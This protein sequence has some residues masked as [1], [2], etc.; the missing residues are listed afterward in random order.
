MVAST[1]NK[2]WQ[3]EKGPK[4]SPEWSPALPRLALLAPEAVGS[5]GDG[6]LPWAIYGLSDMCLLLA[7][8]K[9][10]VGPMCTSLECQPRDLLQLLACR[11]LCQPGPAQQ[12]SWVEAFGPAGQV[13]FGIPHSKDALAPGWL[14]PSGKNS[15]TLPLYC[16]CFVTRSGARCI[17]GHL[18]TLGMKP[19][20]CE[21]MELH[22]HICVP[23]PVLTSML[24][25]GV[26]ICWDFSKSGPCYFLTVRPWD[27]PVPLSYRNLKSYCKY[28]WDHVY[29]C[30]L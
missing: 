29:G 6:D 10:P 26:E 4:Q 24:Q 18:R 11:L 3:R 5:S 27:L 1:I 25:H 20:K 17:W 22:A 7:A 28:Q 9:G 16:T 14:L 23:I 2:Y 8:G 19:S 15:W 30:A 13:P 12:Y 21:D